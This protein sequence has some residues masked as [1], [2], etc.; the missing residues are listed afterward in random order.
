MGFQH[1]A[2]NFQI[3]VQIFSAIWAGDYERELYRDLL[4]QY[5]PLVRP[6]QNES[7]PVDVLLSMDLQQVIDIDEKS[8]IMYANVWLK[9]VRL[10]EFFEKS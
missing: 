9:M 7:Q 3:Y 6:T 8:Q 1:S 4:A 2:E 10:F 5:D